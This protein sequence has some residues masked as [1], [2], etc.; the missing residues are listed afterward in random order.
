MDTFDKFL[1]SNIKKDHINLD[2][3]NSA[4]NQ[5][6]YMV[7]LNSTKSNVKRN[8]IFSFLSDF[9]SPRFIAVKI[10]FVA[11]LFILVFDNKETKVYNVNDLLCDSTIIQNNSFDST[12]TF[13]NQ[14]AD[15][16]FN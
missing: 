10:A 13:N 12:A 8:S 15:S 6:H 14:V 4:F 3:D 2:L 11:M 7:N 5:F 1:N 16:L 9:L